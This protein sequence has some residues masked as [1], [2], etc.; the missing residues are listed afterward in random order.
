MSLSLQAA[1]DSQTGSGNISATFT[2]NVTAGSTIFVACMSYPAA[3]TFSISDLYS[4]GGSNS[5]STAKGPSTGTEDTSQSW[6]AVA[7]QTGS[8]TITVNSSQ[9]FPVLIIVEYPASLGI[10]AVDQ[11]AF[12]DSASGTA[13]ASGAVT[14][15]E[16][17]ELLIGYGGSE[18]GGST[19][20]AG[21]GFAFEESVPV[22]AGGNCFFLEDQQV[23]STGSYQATATMGTGQSWFCALVTL[24]LSGAPPPGPGGAAV[25]CLMQ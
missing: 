24:K 19:L 22:G 7:T 4:G 15:T 2:A 23:S 17:S 18:N 8:L 9:S 10:G 1:Q 11:T 5:Y 20:A 25:V 6:T 16:A 21:A 12:A 13:L 3:G 14:T